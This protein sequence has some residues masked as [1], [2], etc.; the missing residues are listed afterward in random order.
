MVVARLPDAIAAC[1]CKVDLASVERLMWRLWGRDRP[2]YAWV[3]VELAKGG[4]K[5]SV[6]TPDSP[7][8]ETWPVVVAA[9]RKGRPIELE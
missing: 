7:W 2:A 3:P 6:A 1:D 5:V 4:T 9:A 8:S